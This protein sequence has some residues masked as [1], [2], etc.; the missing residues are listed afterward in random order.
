MLMGYRWD[1]DWWFTD[2]ILVGHDAV[3][4]TELPDRLEV[5]YDG[6]SG[7]QPWH[8]RQ[9][10]WLLPAASRVSIKLSELQPQKSVLVF[11]A[12]DVSVTGPL[13][14]QRAERV[15]A[16]MIPS[17]HLHKLVLQALRRAMTQLLLGP[18]VLRWQMRRWGRRRRS[19]P[20]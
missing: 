1:A 4:V 2:G 15:A 11:Q 14:A 19:W 8:V 9:I 17:S 6:S 13:I 7:W 20:R 16:V 12:I 10:D 5:L 3:R 18:L